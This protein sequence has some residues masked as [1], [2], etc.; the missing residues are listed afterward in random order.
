[1]NLHFERAKPIF[2]ILPVSWADLSLTIR[3]Q[4]LSKEVLL[5]FVGQRASKL[6]AVKFGDLKKILPVGLSRTRL[7]RPGFDSWTMGIILQL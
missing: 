5:V 2:K 6:Q 7:V 1:M 4:D 3:S